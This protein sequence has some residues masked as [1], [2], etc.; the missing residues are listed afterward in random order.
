MLSCSCSPLACL[1]C[2]RELERAKRFFGK[3]MMSH[4]CLRTVA[5][6]A[7][8]SIPILPTSDIQ[9]QGVNSASQTQSVIRPA[10]AADDAYAKVDQA[11]SAIDAHSKE[12]TRLFKTGKSV[13]DRESRMQWEPLAM[14]LRSAGQGFLTSYPNDPRRWQVAKWLIEE[15]PGFIDSIDAY[16]EHEPGAAKKAIHYNVDPKDA[17]K[18]R[19]DELKDNFIEA[20]AGSIKFSEG[21]R[22]GLR[23]SRLFSR[24]S[25]GESMAT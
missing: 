11:Q 19:I 7:I 17:W 3:Q 2:D 10:G 6:A 16:D 12:E 23:S 9:S 13:P 24:V 1:L 8:L 14:D 18:Q 4:M 5:A 25:D 21:K 20:N 15:Q 22:C